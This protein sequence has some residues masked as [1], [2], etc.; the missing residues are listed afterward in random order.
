[1][2]PTYFPLTTWREG[3]YEGATE[4][5]GRVLFFV[6]SKTNV[7]ARFQVVLNLLLRSS[8][9][10]AVV[11]PEKDDT[12]GTL[13]FEAKDVPILEGAFRH[14]SCE[15]GL[16]ALHGVLGPEGDAYGICIGVV[17]EAASHGP[18]GHSFEF[19]SSEWGRWEAA[20]STTE[21]DPNAPL[22]AT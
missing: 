22:F 14:S 8:P 20:W 1:M 7:I 5:G 6:P 17:N 15:E 18:W 12:A 9:A 3:Y 10:D 16:F 2:D 21:D 11:G 19:G 4:D 13:R